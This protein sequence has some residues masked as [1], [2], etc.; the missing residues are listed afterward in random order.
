M[1][2]ALPRADAG[3]KPKG[4][5]IWKKIQDRLGLNVPI[6]L[7]MVKY[8]TGKALIFLNQIETKL[9]TN[10]AEVQSHRL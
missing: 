4:P 8:V 6:V 1:T 2:E 9:T 7:I 3:A 10:I 5:S